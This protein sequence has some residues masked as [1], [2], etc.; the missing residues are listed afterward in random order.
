ML[1]FVFL[2]AHLMRR[3][4]P[5]VIQIHAEMAAYARTPPLDPFVIVQK[6]SGASTATPKLTWIACHTHVKRSEFALQASV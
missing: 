3:R 6:D 5:P 4:A 1:A 2:Q